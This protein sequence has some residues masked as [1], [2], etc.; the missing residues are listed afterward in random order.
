MF[1]RK[2]IGF[3][4]LELI[5]VMV[6]LGMMIALVIPNIGSGQVTI[7]N[8]QV[9][10][11]MAVLKHARR[12]AIVEGK[13]RVAI[14]QEGKNTDKAIVA[15]GHWVSNG[16]TLQWA[17]KETVAENSDKGKKKAAI[18]KITFYPEGGSSGGELILIYQGH[19][20]KISINPLTGKIKSEVLYEEK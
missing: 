6:I 3:S 1:I 9:R 10:G 14:L 13:Q 17:D 2:E 12:S 7:L 18:H 19:K 15:P 20:A 8:S 11:A 16:A 5:V 4:L